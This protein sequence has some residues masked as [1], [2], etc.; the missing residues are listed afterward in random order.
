MS[1]IHVKA[2]RVATEARAAA[3]AAIRACLVLLPA[4]CASVLAADVAHADR[5]S[6]DWSG[7]AEVRGNYYW[8]QSTRVVAP[9]VALSVE[10]PNGV[11]LKGH[12]LVDSI[13]SA[14][15]A[16]GVRSDVR[17]T[18]VRHDFGLGAGY[19]FD[20]GDAQFDL[21]A[22]GR[23]SDEPDYT[24][25]SAT[26][27]TTLNLND[28][29]TEIRLSL[30]YVDDTIGKILRGANR[31]GDDGRNLSDRGTVG[32][33]SGVVLS[34]G[35]GQTLTPTLT[36][37]LGYDL[38]ALHG[39]LSNAYRQVSVDGVLRDELHPEDRLR[40]TFHARLAWFFRPTST[41]FH[42][43]YRAYVDSWDV[44]ALTPEGRIYQDLGEVA[45]LR[46]RYR[47]YTQTRAHFQQPAYTS[48][49]SYYT[50]DPKLSEF[51]SNLAGA[52]LLLKL[53]FL[54]DSPLDFAR[55]ST[56]SMGLEYIWNTNSYG[57]AVLGSVALRVPF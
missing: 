25:R 28:R 30:T 51:H 35:W 24:A 11:R 3:V 49:D 50:A 18:E 20:L 55:R 41:A 47:H 5:A 17:F 8:E 10:A 26:L 27:A 4:L 52:M 39:L 54:E 57:N 53:A 23:Y 22:Y 7:L 44:A 16:A 45:T 12:Y 56:L 1:T 29:A 19:E 46:L 6:G 42:L 36:L 38:G 33:L 13:T 31:V 21:S 9:E 15:L 34:A 40:H 14:S 37:D 48:E 2:P 43:L 32:D